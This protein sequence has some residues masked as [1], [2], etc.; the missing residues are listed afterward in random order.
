[1][2]DTKTTIVRSIGAQVRKPATMQF[3]GFFLLFALLPL[4]VHQVLLLGSMLVFGVFAVSYNLLLGYSGVVSFG[5]AVFFGVGTY[6]T[7]FAVQEWGLS[8]F[9]A[10][11]VVLVVAIV[12][13]TVIG[14]VSLQRRGLYFAMITLALGQAVYSLVF[15]SSATGGSNGLR[16]TERTVPLFLDY[17]HLDFTVTI[18]S[19][20]VVLVGA[21]L[22]VAALR[23]I[24]NSPFGLTLRAI[25]ENEERANYVGYNVTSILLFAFVV[26]AVFSAVIGMLNVL[27]V[28]IAAPGQLHWLTSGDVLIMT[29]LGGVGSFFGPL[30]GAVVFIALEELFISLLGSDLLPIG[31]VLLI[32]VMVLPDGLVSLLDRVRDWRQ[33][34]K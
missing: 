31:L 4:V 3:V 12:I 18:F 1:M 6:S 8:F 15:N 26:S 30:I 29:L 20:Y 2:T 13:G 21:V 11:G 33:D 25:R 14:L 10:L 24:V 19:Y 23:R 34:R 5:H 28:G 17:V 7:I 27:M 22:L 9:G 16:F 32:A